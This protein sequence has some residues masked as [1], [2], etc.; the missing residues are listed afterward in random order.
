[1]QPA[2]G[3]PH[4]LFFRAKRQSSGVTRR[5]N[6]K[7][8]LMKTQ[9]LRPSSLRTQGPITSGIHDVARRSNRDM[10]ALHN[11]DDTAYGSLRSH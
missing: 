3:I 1:V 4:A 9:Y 11:I 2:P 10:N 8:C 7:T 6:E 5:E